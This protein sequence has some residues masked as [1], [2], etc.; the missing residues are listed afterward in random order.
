MDVEADRNSG[1]YMPNALEWQAD[2]I[3][4]VLVLP[5]LH[6]GNTF[7]ATSWRD[8]RQHWDV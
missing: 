8:L 7:L 2:K 1:I 3:R 4:L 5:A 6:E